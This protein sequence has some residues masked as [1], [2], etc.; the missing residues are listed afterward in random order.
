MSD[1]MQNAVGSAAD[2]VPVCPWCS[3]P[4]PDAEAS[5]CPSCY[6]MLR[7]A[8]ATE[9]PGVTRVDLEA[10]LQRRPRA[11]RSR[12]L[13]GWLSGEYQPE[14]PQELHETLAPP[15]GDVRRE[16]LRLE[17]AALEAEANAERAAEAALVADAGRFLDA[18]EAGIT[19]AEADGDLADDVAAGSDPVGGAAGL[20]QPRED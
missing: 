20:E 12:G 8:A 6:A 4:L 16:M 2:H 13:I 5:R 1:E 17:L 15:D 3:A 7:E 9:V 19:P 10:V 11:G 18:A 14:P